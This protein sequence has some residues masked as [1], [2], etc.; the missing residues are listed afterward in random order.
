MQEMTTELRE[1]Y[2]TQELKIG[3]ENVKIE[4]KETKIG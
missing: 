3:Q 1:V 4:I 2:I